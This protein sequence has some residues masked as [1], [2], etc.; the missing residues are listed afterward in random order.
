MRC[1]KLLTQKGK[2]KLTQKRLADAIGICRE[3]VSAIECG[4]AKQ[5]D[6]ML[7]DTMAKWIKACECTGIAALKKELGACVISKMNGVIR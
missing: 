7:L 1:N 5:I 2:K 3:N 6:N 4:H